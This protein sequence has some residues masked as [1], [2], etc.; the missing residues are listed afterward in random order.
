M[1]V[2]FDNPEGL[3]SKGVSSYL[4]FE[5]R[6]DMKKHFTYTKLKLFQIFEYFRGISQILNLKNSFFF[7]D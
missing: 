5:Y 3:S 6:G 4:R 7:E 2:D 1:I